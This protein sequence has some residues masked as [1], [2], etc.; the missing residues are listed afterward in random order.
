MAGPGGREVGRI[1][2]KVVPDTDGFRARLVAA[3]NA[4]EKGVKAEI[5]VDLKENEIRARMRALAKDL[6]AKIEA[7]AD[8]AK[9]EAALR[10]LVRRRTAHIEVEMNAN[11]IRQQLNEGFLRDAINRRVEI[12]VDAN[13]APAEANI[14]RLVGTRRKITVEVDLDRHRGLFALNGRGRFSRL[15]AGLFNGISRLLATTLGKALT[16]G[17]DLA[18]K[19]VAT[20]AGFVSS[21]LVNAFD[22]ATTGVKGFLNTVTTGMASGTAAIGG[23]LAQAVAMGPTIAIAIAAFAA[24]GVIVGGVVLAI[25]GYIGTLAAAIT[26]LIA[27]IASVL[28]GAAALLVLPALFAGVAAAIIATDDELRKDFTDTLKDMASTVKT[29]AMPAIDALKGSLEKVH[30]AMQVGQP[31]YDALQRGFEATAKALVPLTEGMINFTSNALAGMATAMQ[32]LVANGA[33]QGVSQ[34]LSVLGAAIGEFFVKLSA[35]GPQ[36]AAAFVALA[37]A[38]QTISGPLASFIGAFSAVAP[39][40]LAAV[41]TALATLFN[42]LA[43][44]AGPLAMAATALAEAFTKMVPSFVRMLTAFAQISPDVLDQMANAMIKIMDT[45]SRPDVI[46]AI[47]IM[48]NLLSNLIGIV[49]PALLIQISDLVLRFAAAWQGLVTIVQS[50]WTA[51]TTIVTAAWALIG[52]AISAGIAQVQAILSGAWS[53]I[54]S[55]ASAAWSAIGTIITTAWSF[56]SAAVSAGIAQVQSILSGAWSAIQSTVSSAWSAIQSVIASAL[57]AIQSAMSAAWSAV[58]SAVAAAWAAIQ[59]AIAA[60]LS[61]IQSAVQAGVAAVV[62]AITGGW[63]G[64][65]GIVSGIFQGIVSA[66]QSAMSAALSAVQSTVSAITSAISSIGGAI[67][68]V[69]GGIGDA[70]FGS[71]DST[72]TPNIHLAS[73]EGGGDYALAG[74]AGMPSQARWGRAILSQFEDAPQPRDGSG[75]HRTYNVNVTAAPNIPTEEQITRQLSYAD[76]I[77][78][79]GLGG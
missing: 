42:A 8:T 59:A 45:L 46:A 38:F 20:F 66:I 24:F 70:L 57:S 11:R 30:Q 40:V 13:T 19:A 9:A 65:V 10:T 54:Q 52:A 1:S 60:A 62:A 76:T 58:Q 17:F 35:F 4:A 55:I 44:N 14:Q 2:I 50:A 7:Q 67:G 48:S 78:G 77:Y 33:F 32:N 27:V 22:G 56:I 51:I 49:I 61:A 69:A 21:A 6:K 28:V 26:G 41:A 36:I 18:A 29:L 68:G 63:S 5:P 71:W 23:F 15:F 53:S 74:A 47:T 72:I 34:A 3:V 79:Q 43:A 75:T 12:D 31:L 39:G 64:L 16:L 37:Q 25:I 73:L